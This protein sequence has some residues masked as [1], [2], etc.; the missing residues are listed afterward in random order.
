MQQDR[1]NAR[2][3]HT[4]ELSIPLVD[5]QALWDVFSEVPVL[6]VDLPLTGALHLLHREVETNQ[7]HILGKH[8]DDRG[9]V[10]NLVTVRF[11]HVLADLEDEVLLANTW[12]LLADGVPDIEP[13]LADHC[14]PFLRLSVPAFIEERVVGVPLAFG[15]PLPCCHEPRGVVVCVAAVQR[16][17]D[18]RTNRAANLAQHPRENSGRPG[19]IL[20]R[21]RRKVIVHLERR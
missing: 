12:I 11:G 17:A 3:R 19:S 20:C 5:A 2:R 14:A 8:V 18:E 4:R 16:K 1:I 7:A 6:E 13:L 9:G 10:C 15:V 21:Q